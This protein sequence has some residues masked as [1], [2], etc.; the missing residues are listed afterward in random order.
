MRFEKSDTLFSGI[1]KAYV[2][3]EAEVASLF[4]YDFQ[5]E[6][7]FYRRVDHLDGNRNIPRQQ[8]SQF[9]A[10]FQK[11]LCQA[12]GL[13]PVKNAAVENAL[14][15]AESNSLAMVTGQQAG[16]FTGPLYT[17]YK[18]ITCIAQARYW[19]ERLN[20]PVIP[21]FWVA[22]EDHDFEESSQVQVLRGE[23][24]LRVTVTESPEEVRQAV[25]H[26]PLPEDLLAAVDEFLAAVADTTV[27]EEWQPLLRDLP[28]KVTS[29]NGYF[30]AILHRLLGSYGLVVLDPLMPGLKALPESRDFF[31][32]V[33]KK[34]AA[35][36]EGLAEGVTAVRGLGYTPQVEKKTTD[37]H[38][39]YYR[40]RERLA[41]ER[42]SEGFS[43]RGKKGIF[44]P[45]EIFQQIQEDPEAF[46]PSVV[47]RPLWQ[48][49]LLPTLAYIAGPG[50]IAYFASY[51]PVY[52]ALGMEM[53][54][55]IPRL[56]ATLVEGFIDR[57]LQKYDISSVQEIRQGL[58]ERLNQLVAAQDELGIDT[59]FAE[60]QAKVKLAYEP[61]LEKI[62]RWDGT[63]GKAAEENLERVLGQVQ[64]LQNKVHQ[65]HRQRCQ[66]SRNHFDKVKKHLWPGGPQERVL[67]IFPY[68]FKYDYGIIG[69]LIELAANDLET[70]RVLYL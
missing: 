31:S 57:L 49:C 36:S 5:D 4:S 24:L 44:S 66:E 51:K 38:M 41:L 58:E 10:D 14:R 55:I 32:L 6:R 2:E 48:D 8:V 69:Q 50:E 3:R 47:T 30:A 23:Q 29:L 68:L 52:E 9:L 7:S 27:R 37:A 16:L 11:Q 63:I 56:S 15:L 39:F 18:A 35:L 28:A 64:F 26:R 43:L 70:H 19:E 20:R 46:S 12:V 34:S 60:L 65:R 42:L 61:V 54:P 53:P 25:G 21:I 33:M 45:D 67:N 17:V 1:A 13:D 62:S 40:E 59:L 22:S